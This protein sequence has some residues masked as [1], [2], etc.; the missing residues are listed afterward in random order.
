MRRPLTYELFFKFHF[1]DLTFF[2]LQQQCRFMTFAASFKN[3]HYN[4]KIYFL[5]LF[6][7]NLNEKRRDSVETSPDENSENIMYIFRDWFPLSLLQLFYY[8]CEF[9]NFLYI[10]FMT[11]LDYFQFFS[12]KYIERLYYH[13]NDNLF[14]QRIYYK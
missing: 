14:M 3:G 6:T 12:C 13:S 10:F 1:F 4:C 2:F 9:D 8:F 5:E 7:F 11:T